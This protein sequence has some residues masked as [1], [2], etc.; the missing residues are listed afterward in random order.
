MSLHDLFTWIMGGGAL[1]YFIVAMVKP[2]WF[3]YIPPEQRQA[4]AE[5]RRLLASD[6]VEQEV[7]QMQPMAGY[8]LKS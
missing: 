2:E 4:Q 8:Y 5:Q 7:E 6:Q 3:L 1:L